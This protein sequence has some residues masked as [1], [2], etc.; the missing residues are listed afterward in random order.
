MVAQNVEHGLGQSMNTPPLPGYDGSLHPMPFYHLNEVEMITTRPHRQLDM[1]N[2]S[3]FCCGCLCN[4]NPSDVIK[5]DSG[6]FLCKQC[7]PNKHPV[8]LLKQEEDDDDE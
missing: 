1:F 3:F 6:Y 7:H 8:W 5:Q 2:P 4:L